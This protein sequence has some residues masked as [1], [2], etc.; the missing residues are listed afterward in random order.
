[1]RDDGDSMARVRMDKDGGLRLPEKYALEQEW[2]LEQTEDGLALR[3]IRPDARRAYVEITAQC[4]LNCAM[5]VRQVWRDPPGAMTWETFQAVVEGLRAFPDLEEFTFGGYGEPLSHPRF[6]EMVY[7]AGT[8]GV[9]TTVTTNGLLLD[10][11]MAEALI[12]ARL[13][14]IVV[15]LDTVHAQAYPQA[16]ATQGVQRVLDNLRVLR[17]RATQQ[18]QSRPASAWSS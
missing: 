9:K 1:M 12:A 4:N 7:L 2:L 6:P 10:E 3:A 14:T 18:G 8:L 11:A 17:E 16:G 15:S 13:D 5:C